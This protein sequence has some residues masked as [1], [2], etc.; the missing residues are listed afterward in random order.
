MLEANLAAT[1]EEAVF[2]GQ[3]FLKEMNFFYHVCFDHTF[4]D[5]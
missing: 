2:L 5:G 4:K 1:R 3:R